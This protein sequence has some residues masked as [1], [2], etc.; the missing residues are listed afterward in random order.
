MLPPSLDVSW[1]D[2]R[3]CFG[4]DQVWGARRLRSGGPSLRKKNHK[5]KFTYESEFLFRKGLCM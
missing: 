5:Y 2:S 1:K 3:G 4:A